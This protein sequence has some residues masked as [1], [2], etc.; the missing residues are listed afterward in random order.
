MELAYDFTYTPQVRFDTLNYLKGVTD[1]NERTVVVIERALYPIENIEKVLLPYFVPIAVVE[2][3]KA[4]KFLEDMLLPVLHHSQV[5]HA[6]D[7]IMK[8]RHIKII[9]D[10]VTFVRIARCGFYEDKREAEMPNE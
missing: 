6:V 4:R 2:E 5:S 3:D 10:N 9:G 1:T 8:G 7:G